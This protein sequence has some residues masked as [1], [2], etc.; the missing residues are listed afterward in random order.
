MRQ[1]LGNVQEADPEVDAELLHHNTELTLGPAN[2]SDRNRFHLSTKYDLFARP[3]RD[4]ITGR[5]PHKPRL[6]RTRL[7]NHTTSRSRTDAER[8][9]ERTTDKR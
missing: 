3:R 6:S 8:Y 1:P 4:P 9:F 7:Y 2:R 5:Q